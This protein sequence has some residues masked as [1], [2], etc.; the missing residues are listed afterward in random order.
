MRIAVVASLAMCLPMTPSLAQGPAAQ[1]ALQA[2]PAP[3]T[4]R[5][6]LTVLGRTY[7][8]VD[9]DPELEIKTTLEDAERRGRGRGRVI[10]TSTR[11][12]TI[13]LIPLREKYIA[14]HALA[15]TDD[16]VAAAG[17]KLNAARQAMV[18]RD[19]QVAADRTAELKQ[20]LAKDGLTPDERQRAEQDLKSY[21]SLREP[22]LPRADPDAPLEP[23]ERDLYRAMVTGWKFDKALYD[24]CGGRV[25]FQQMGLEPFDAVRLW[26]E[27]Q[28]RAGAF[29]FN[30][31]GL[32]DLFYHYYRA[33]HGAF[34]A[35]EAEGKAMMSKPWW[36]Q[37]PEPDA[38]E[39]DAPR[40][41][42]PAQP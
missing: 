25:L 21:E 18:E 32:R 20:R 42:Q 2:A 38:L 36:E 3:A 14:D 39:A 8:T 1:P 40:I 12:V 16:E 30:H 17:M 9:F 13:V 28:E 4:P 27:E 23:F 34:L 33:D 22:V 24:H 26:L 35:D 19:Q 6:L 15:A 41:D 10:Y 29:T 31:D 11:L 37:T 7:T 5:T